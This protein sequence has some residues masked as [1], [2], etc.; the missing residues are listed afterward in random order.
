MYEWRVGTWTGEGCRSHESHFRGDCPTVGG[1]GVDSK[2]GRL[3]WVGW[4][5]VNR[6]IRMAWA[7][8]EVGGHVIEDRD[9]ACDSAFIFLT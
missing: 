1:Q 4:D 3:R 8:G 2:L 7:C 6:Q 5:E 9:M